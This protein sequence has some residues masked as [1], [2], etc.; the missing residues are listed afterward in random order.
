MN[1]LLINQFERKGGAAVIAATL[2]KGYLQNGVQSTYLVSQ[3]VD[4]NS[5]AE[6]IPQKEKG[7]LPDLI[8]KR[9]QTLPV[10]SNRL[11]TIEKLFLN[12]LLDPWQVMTYLS[13]RENHHHMGV[14]RWLRN[15]SKPFNVL[16][17]HNLHHNYFDLRLLRKI[18]Y[19]MP[20][21][22]T[23][24]DTW[25]FAG[26]C[27][28]FLDCMRWKTGCGNCPDLKRY[29]SIR[30]DATHKNWFAKSKIFGN[31]QIY[32][33]APS[34]WIL[35]EAE[36]SLLKP[37]IR[38]ARVIRN[39]IDLS[40]FK[41]KD[42][43]EIRKRLDLPADAKVILF[44]ANGLRSNHYKDFFTFDETYRWF[45]EN[46]DGKEEVIFVGLGD[47][48]GTPV[49]GDLVSMRTVL[50]INQP[51]LV[52]D[53]YNAADIYFHPVKIDNFP[54]TILEA[55]A[56]GLPVVASNVGGIPEQV[57]NGETGYLVAHGNIEEMVA[58]IKI[59]LCDDALRLQMG[60]K[61]AQIAMDQYNQEKMV[62]TY[63]QYFQEIQED[64]LNHTQKH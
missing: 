61:A 14:K 6:C 51:E 8:R 54:T 3:A 41:V 7:I 44:V 58:A 55:M 43:K 26:H 45:V 30:R 15:S 18:S 60:R 35:D 34:Q 11:Q 16:H 21:V 17:L 9:S 47:D 39:G 50:M 5:S 48:E 31:S 46:W 38:M 59:I 13:G 4:K 10:F 42:K 27:G 49:S 37:A 20:V 33:T 52:A 28:Y 19:E 12:F 36:H 53:Y 56:C 63:L 57:L 29:P 40:V 62:K 2:H 32:M 64:W 24:H 22:I 23:L 25:L 1:V